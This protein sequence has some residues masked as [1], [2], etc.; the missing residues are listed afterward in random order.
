MTDTNHRPPQNTPAADLPPFGPLLKRLR[1]EAGL[2][3]EE[4]ADKAQLSPRAISDLERGINKTARKETARL[5]AEALELDGGRR[6][7]FEGV[8][9]GRPTVR[10]L[11]SATRTLPRDIA[12]FVGREAEL[13]SLTGGSSNPD[14]RV[15]TIGGMAGVGKTALAVRAAHALAAQFPDGQIFLQLH[16]HTPGHDAVNVA[17]ALASL[18]H[19]VGISAQQMP[20]G[21]EA[22]A[23]LW[24]DRVAGKKL[25][26]VLDDAVDSDQ[27]R[28]LLPGTSECLVL[29]TSR[30]HLSALE[31]AKA[32][33]IDALPAHEA[34]LLFVRLADR[35]DLV[36]DD[37]AIQELVNLCGQLPLALGLLARRLH[38]HPAWTAADLAMELVA[39]RSRLSFMEAEDQSV[40]A[41][42]QVSFAD[43]TP[44]QQ[45]VFRRLGLYP[46]TDIDAYV[47]AAM[48]DAGLDA[49]RRSLEGLYDHYLLTE[50][51][52]GRYRMHDLIKEYARTA[53]QNDQRA[54]R[55]AV[56]DRVLNYF[57]H[58]ARDADLHLGRRIPAIELAPPTFAPELASRV[59]AVAWLEAER[60]NLHAAAQ[61]AAAFDRPG[62]AVAIP[63]A[64]H[65]FLRSQ[66]YWQQALELDSLALEAA[67]HAGGQVAEARALTDL[68]DMQYLTDDYIAA[69]ATLAR[70]L[71]LYRILGQ[72][73]GEA[74]A[75]TLLGAVQR[76]AGESLGALSSLNGA[77][78]LYRSLGDRLGEANALTEL[79]AVQRLG[80]EFGAANFSLTTALAV[81]RDLGNRLGQANALLELSAVELAQGHHEA[82]TAHSK[83]ALLI[84]HELSDL[85]GEARD[86]NGLAEI[87]AANGAS[88]EAL[89]RYGQAF[90]IASSISALRE[91]ARALEGL[92]HCHR[93]RGQPVQ[94]EDALRQ[95]LAIYE[96][97]RSPRV[98]DVVALLEG[99]RHP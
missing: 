76:G 16:A 64:L 18:L 10:G 7:E 33:S 52:K 20:V 74:N 40:A 77:V 13:E 35:P 79:G 62:H 47:A 84:H 26:L 38:H 3:Q 72:R 57:V 73:L 30:R 71:E 56:V 22:R 32:V 83:D 59:D 39:A 93:T 17:E 6:E 81:F 37:P 49:A 23:S 95:A 87:A 89:I 82:A 70:A 48:D 46:G 61:Y 45:R 78:K 53:A 5:L 36:I 69:Q 28:P 27:V 1:E 98:G 90:S 19:I 50:L 60:L 68:A 41:A 51:A 96:Q 21:E 58:T 24:R 14:R 97:L 80:G 43:L 4:L 9:R 88:D 42:F 54:E 2:T 8:A 75:L 11:A 44:A 94:A 63:E 12:S 55:V 86:L 29:V 67:H 15:C 92:A 31:D 34:A 66:G 85:P 91:Q 25:L 65:E 99:L